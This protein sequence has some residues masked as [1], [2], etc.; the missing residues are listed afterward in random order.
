MAEKRDSTIDIYKGIGIILVM[1]GHIGFGAT[2]SYIA[3][4]FHMPMFFFISGYLYRKKKESFVVWFERKAGALLKPYLLFGILNY[5]FWIFIQWQKGEPISLSPIGHLLFVNTT[6]LASGSLWFLTALFITNMA[7]FVIEKYISHLAWKLIVVVVISHLGIMAAEYLPFRLPYAMDAGMVGV[8]LFYAGYMLKKFEDKKIIYHLFHLSLWELVIGI[9]LISFLILQHGEIN[10]RIGAYHNII[11][12]WNNAIIGSILIYNLANQIGKLKKYGM[13][14]KTVVDLGEAIGRNSLMYVCMND[15][16]NVE[17]LLIIGM[18]VTEKSKLITAV[19]H[20]ATLL[21]AIM[22]IEI[23]I[24]YT[25]V[26]K[27]V[28]YLKLKS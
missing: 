3:H 1:M 12:F 25:P 21:L 22:V 5:F 24:R 28:D 14:F 9:V 27:L 13:V 4:A 20:S 16:I 17:V 15:L 26:V 10:M 7:F 11:L 19:T 23:V 8:G 18:F 6:G 2:S